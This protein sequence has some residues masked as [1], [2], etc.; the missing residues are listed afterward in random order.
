M[1]SNDITISVE[2]HRGITHQAP[3]DKNIAENNLHEDIRL[4]E[5]LLSKRANA[6][7]QNASQSTDSITQLR[8]K[9]DPQHTYIVQFDGGSRGNPGVSGA[10]ALILDAERN[11]IWSTHLFV[12]NV[13][14]NNEA[15]Y[16]GAIAGLEA[17][18]QLGIQQ[19]ILQGDSSLIIRQVMGVYK[20]KSST[21]RPLHHEAL[22][23]ANQFHNF[24]AEHIPRNL[25]AIADGLSNK[26][27]D[28]RSKESLDDV[29]QQSS[30]IRHLLERYS[31]DIK[32]VQF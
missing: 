25:N 20:V 31:C 15:E 12:G 2:H 24:T 27:M 19:V 6:N 14:T 23:L 26:A 9:I 18:K 3:S 11:I 7:T 30:V 10:G 5:I 13:V 4:G 1:K 32:T 29:L 21:L 8:T 22:K 28:S 17:A 16:M